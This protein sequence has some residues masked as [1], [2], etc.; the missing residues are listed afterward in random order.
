MIKI[1]LWLFSYI[2]MVNYYM[3]RNKSKMTTIHNI[4]NQITSLSCFQSKDQDARQL[5]AAHGLWRQQWKKSILKRQPP[6][7]SLSSSA[8]KGDDC[9]L[10]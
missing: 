2:E 8:L 4:Q 9:A 7:V 3:E 10:Q 1:L 6:A 5:H